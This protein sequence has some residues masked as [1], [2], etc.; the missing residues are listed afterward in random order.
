[1]KY[2]FRSVSFILATG[3]SAFFLFAI[4][5]LLTDVLDW[6]NGAP[7]FYPGKSLRKL[8]RCKHTKEFIT[9]TGNPI[10]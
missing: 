7:F 4:C 8:L 9:I 1:M 3:A 2:L 5:Y 6:W 10:I